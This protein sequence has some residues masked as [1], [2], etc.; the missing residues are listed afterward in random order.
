MKTMC[1][2][3]QFLTIA[4]FTIGI[5]TSC[6]NSTSDE[7]EEVNGKT[8]KK[9]IQSVSVVSA[10]DPSDG[11]TVLFTYDSND[12]LT[13]VT[14]GLET[15]IF[16]YS[17]GELSTAAGQD[18]T[19]SME[20]LYASPY[21]AFN[22][23]QIEEYDNNGNPAKILFFVSEYNYASGIN[24]V[25]QY[26][27]EISYDDKPNPFYY[28]LESAGIIDVLDGVEFNLSMTPQAPELV[29][30][31]ALFPNNNP[32]QLAYKN[33][34]GELVHVIN[35]DYA[36]EGDYPTSGTAV[37]VSPLDNSTGTVSITFQYTN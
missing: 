32:S 6:D 30:A 8:D 2:K 34:A 9:R 15:Y 29:R 7:F 11:K 16:A 20:E 17:N 27:L 24:E 21:D 35:F 3:L 19:L 22:T 25:F 37:A 23:G 5:T 31:K 12:R 14:D 4:I 13:S 33:E 10:Q 26:T 28:T 18:G 36:Y 1:P